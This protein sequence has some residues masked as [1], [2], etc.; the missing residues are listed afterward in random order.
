MFTYDATNVTDPGHLIG[1]Q[2]L[3]F[4]ASSSWQ[5]TNHVVVILRGDTFPA[6]ELEFEN[7]Y[8]SSTHLSISMLPIKGNF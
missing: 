4:Q 3:I 6:P 1:Y 2:G 5:A 7:A 8:F